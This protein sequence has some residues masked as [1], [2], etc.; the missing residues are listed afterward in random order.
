MK[1]LRLVEGYSVVL[2]RAKAGCA[3]AYYYYLLCKI[4]IEPNL[5]ATTIAKDTEG[6]FHSVAGN[7]L[8]IAVTIAL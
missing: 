5:D 3:V 2:T 6:P 4:G 7:Y 8:L 1:E